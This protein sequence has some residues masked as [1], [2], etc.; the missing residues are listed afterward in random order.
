MLS[1][2][3]ALTGTEE[4]QAAEH[5]RC[6]ETLAR[7]APDSPTACAGWTA[8]DLA[9]HLWSLK[10]RDPRWWV[11]PGSRRRVARL[12][13]TLRYGELV[14][15]LRATPPGFACMPDDRFN[16][17]LHSL[18]EYYVHGQDVA[19]PAGITRPPLGA[20]LDEALWV[21]AGQAAR[22]LRRRPPGLVL[23]TPDGRSQAVTRGRPRQRVTGPPGE[24]ILWVYGRTS[25]ARVEVEDLAQP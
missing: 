24:V 5:L 22:I 14:D 16:R 4:L 19:R 11:G 17:Y 6:C 25:I 13:E 23:A 15:R 20:A 2:R 7:V 3:S 21:R 9:A 18:G 1:R 8:H 12:K 10:Q